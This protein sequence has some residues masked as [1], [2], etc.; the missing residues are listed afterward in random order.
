MNERRPGTADY[1]SPGT[2]KSLRVSISH[3]RTKRTLHIP[4]HPKGF[5]R[6]DLGVQAQPAQSAQMCVKIAADS[7]SD[8]AIPHSA[9]NP[10]SF[11]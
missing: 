1:K 11:T 5:V 10:K 2:E 6:A 7:F 8:V 3:S 4:H 9:A